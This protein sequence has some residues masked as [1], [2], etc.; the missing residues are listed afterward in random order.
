MTYFQE[1]RVLKPPRFAG[2]ISPGTTHNREVDGSNPSGAI[3]RRFQLAYLTIA[4]FSG[5]PEQLLERYEQ[6]S[7][8]MSG[9]GRDHGLILH[10]AAKTDE[11]LLVINLWPSKDCSE[12]AAGD[13]RRLGVLEQSGVTP[14]D[15]S[16][17]HHEV[18]NYEVFD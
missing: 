16:R 12:A 10:A 11:G 15:I 18:A 2:L 17:E 7:E 3:K 14:G 9:V 5:D 6:S 8:V 13:P 4:R 1:F